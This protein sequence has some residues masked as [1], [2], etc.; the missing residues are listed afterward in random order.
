MICNLSLEKINKK[1]DRLTDWYVG[2]VSS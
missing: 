1:T 2:S